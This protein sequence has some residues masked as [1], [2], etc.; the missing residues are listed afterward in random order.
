MSLWSSRELKDASLIS[1]TNSD[2]EN[3]QVSGI[4]IDS[5]TLDPGDLFIALSG[6]PGAGFSTSSSDPRDGHNFVSSAVANGAA[7]VMVSEDIK[8]TCPKLLVDNTLDGLWRLAAYS[9]KRMQGKIVGITGSSGKTT[10]RQWLEQLLKKQA[11]SGKTHASIGS[12]NNHWGVPLSLA[13]M[14]AES[15]YGIFEIGTNHPGEIAPLSTLV[16]PH[17]ALLL[18]VL[19]AHIGNFENLIAI[20]NE[21]LTIADGLDEGGLMIVPFGMNLQSVKY[22]KVITFGLRPKNDH[23]SKALK[24]DVFGEGVSD[25]LGTRI[26]ANILGEE[27][28]YRLNTYGDHRVLT[29]LAVMA[30]VSA[31][32]ADIQQAAR[33]FESLTN[34]DGRGNEIL[35]NGIRVIDDS[36]NA[37][38]ASMSFAIKALRETP[39]T[40]ARIALLGEML[41]LGDQSQ[42]RH[43]EI[44]K[45]AKALDGVMTI[46]EGFRQTPGN[47]G[48]YASC[49]EIDIAQFLSQVKAGDTLLIKGSNKIFSQSGYVKK[50]VN[51]LGL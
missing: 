49:E 22:N 23:E 48:H 12:L 4:S 3:Y 26:V 51:Y 9:R 10:A 29:S 37:N 20:Q 13:R 39:G 35:I 2:S 11:P 19:P 7:S 21:K 30:M 28:S 5:R 43:Q 8:S 15:K 38:P 6:D 47:W 41:E 17:I 33:D 45:E 24:A 1:A 42:A 34:P 31:L 46:G 36:Y 32:G 16:S 27:V 14:P 40:G 18:N 50:L 44:A 25:S